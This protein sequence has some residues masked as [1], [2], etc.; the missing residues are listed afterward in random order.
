MMPLPHRRRPARSPAD[1]RAFVEAFA[2]LAWASFV[3]AVLPFARLAAIARR[4]V[5][6]PPP[7]DAAR[8]V[9]QVAWAIAAA[10]RRA[11][12]RAVCIERGL[13]AQAMLRRRG[14]AADFHYGLAR[15]PAGAL[16]AH[17]WVRAGDSDVTG[18]DQAAAFHEVAVFRPGDP[19]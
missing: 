8:A 19:G 10:A 11:G 15:D 9:R 1:Y 4:P 2:T 7:A 18:G 5:R 14:I 6:R 12:F 17:V 16:A 13:A 3:V